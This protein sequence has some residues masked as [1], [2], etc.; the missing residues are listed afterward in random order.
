VKID[1]S[2]L[3][4][5]LPRLIARK[6]GFPLHFGSSVR[7][8]V[9]NRTALTDQYCQ[10]T[11]RVAGI[12]AIIDAYVVSEL[13]SLLLG[14]E[15]AQQVNLLSDLGNRTYY[16]PGP[17]GN[18]NELPVHGPMAEAEAETEFAMEAA[19]TREET[20]LAEE[21]PAPP[22]QASPIE[23]DGG[24]LLQALLLRTHVTRR[25]RAASTITQP[26]QLIIG[27]KRGAGLRDI[28]NKTSRQGKIS[29]KISK[30][31]AGTRNIGYQRWT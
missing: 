6:L 20:L 30:R 15:W 10:F 21:T 16:I 13:S 19:L 25:R 7:V 22:L 5:L 9:A 27:E 2:S 26:I 17:H 29:A 4:N 18:L 14:W 1:G 31:T 8:K 24:R 12:N 28:S 23:S 3:H 11:I